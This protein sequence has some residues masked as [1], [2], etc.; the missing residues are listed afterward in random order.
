MQQINRALQGITSDLDPAY[1]GNNNWVFPTHGIR[2]FNRKGQGFI[3]TNQSGTEEEFELNEGYTIIAA[4][5][6]RGIIYLVSVSENTH[7]GDHYT[8]IGC[9]PYP[10]QWLDSTD[11]FSNVYGPIRNY[12]NHALNMMITTNFKFTLEQNK[13]LVIRHSGCWAAW[14]YR[15]SRT[16]TSG[17]NT[18]KYY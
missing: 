10:N 3:I 15:T 6:H 7:E 11:G 5:E 8:E 2:I 9:Y 13:C 12:D 17:K 14:C 16:G 18:C 1:I 4:E